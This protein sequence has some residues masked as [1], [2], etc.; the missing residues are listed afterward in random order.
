MIMKGYLSYTL[1]ILAMVGAG[2]G[3]L[4]GAIE[5]GQALNMFW[6]GAVV[7]GLRR[8]LN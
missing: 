6:A 4:M 5:S 2:A 7:F 8:A 3:Y 1:A